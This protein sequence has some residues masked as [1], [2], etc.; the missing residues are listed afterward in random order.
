[1]SEETSLK[2][3]PAAEASPE[4]ATESESEAAPEK[5][6]VIK[7]ASTKAKKESAAKPKNGAV[8]HPPFANMITAAIKA[9]KDT[10]GSSR[11]AILKYIVANFKVGDNNKAQVRVKLA[12]RKMLESKKLVAG[13]A[14]GKKGAGSFKLATD[15]EPKPIKSKKKSSIKKPKAKVSVKKLTVTIKKPTKKA[16]PSS[17]KKNVPVKKESTKK[18]AVKKVASKNVKKAAAKKK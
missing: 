6:V 16:K 4:E 18:P 15:S 10:N 11:Q 8:S 2:E 1:M 5:E 17:A 12:F 7:A 9:L 13:G 3:T 14:S